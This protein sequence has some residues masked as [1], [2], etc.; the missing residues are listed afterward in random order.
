M[1]GFAALERSSRD[2]LVPLRIFR[3][4]TLTRAN[5]GAL[6]LCGTCFSFQFLVTQYLQ[7]LGRWRC[8]LASP[9]SACGTWKRWPTGWPAVT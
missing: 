6:V 4:G 1:A 9:R 2:P 7:T 5:I 8:S 3:S